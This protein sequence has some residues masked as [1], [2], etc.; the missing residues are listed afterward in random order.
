MVL[1]S[2]EI[3]FVQSKNCDTNTEIVASAKMLLLGKNLYSNAYLCSMPIRVFF[4]GPRFSLNVSQNLYLV[5]APR[6]VISPPLRTTGL[7]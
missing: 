2:A 5:N 3:L 6:W 1:S 4:K 7:N